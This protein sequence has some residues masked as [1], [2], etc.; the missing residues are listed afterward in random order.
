M[1]VRL[2]DGRIV[3][4]V[5]DGTTKEEILERLGETAAPEPTATPADKPPLSASDVVGGAVSNFGPDAV[6]YGKDIVDGIVQTVAHPVDTAKAF[7]SL[8]TGAVQKVRNLSPPDMRGSE[9]AFDE[10]VAD[11]VGEDAKNAYGSWEAIKRR[12]AERPVAFIGDLS[13]ALV[14]GPG[15]IGKVGKII[16]PVR[17][18]GKAADKAG[19]LLNTV[20]RVEAGSAT[21]TGLNALKTAGEAGEAGGRQAQEF[22]DNLRGDV[23]VENVVGMADRALNN[24]VRDRANQ[25]RAQKQGWAGKPDVL[26]FNPVRKAIADAAQVD[27]FEGVSLKPST[28]KVWGEV[29]QAV[30]KWQ[31]ADPA[32]FHTAEGFDALKKTLQDI[33]NGIPFE[34]R[35]A[36]K[37]VAD[38]RN[39]VKDQIVAQDPAYGKAMLDYE[40]ASNQISEIQNTLSLG[41]NK[42]SIDT[43]LRKLQSVMRNNVNTNYGAR[44]TLANTLVDAG[45]AKD[46]F[47]ALAGQ[48]LN[49]PLPRGIA[50][51][52]S[53]MTAAVLALS[54]LKALPL[55]ATA[56]PRLMGETAYYAGKARG[57]KNR[58][59][60][61]ARTVTDRI[62][63]D[64]VALT[65][66]ARFNQAAKEEDDAPDLF[67]RGGR[68]Q[69]SD[70]L[71]ARL[72]R[73]Q[74]MA[75]RRGGV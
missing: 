49:N 42:R 36:R 12:I 50:S 60:N 19:D 64:P 33:E 34:N 53:P 26:N 51:G 35:S 73:L 67:A 40:K 31:K 59:M 41:R 63:G 72:D 44:E 8:V 38:V 66:A 61:A 29:W 68:A 43:A 65:E 69:R 22:L 45:G 18:A 25:Y 6:R 5:P 37:V 23:P 15:V 58:G 24:L 9:P 14:G 46:L 20:A 39:K 28:E 75:K 21:G 74:R 7:G 52:T 47:P 16:D 55:M 4:N 54:S 30:D 48:A 57:V 62:P 17:V 70:A 13:T 3:R 27:T 2:P 11:V 71:Q 56:S 1:D 32:K 10:S